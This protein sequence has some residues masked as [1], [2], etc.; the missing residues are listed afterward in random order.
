MK[1]IVHE[2]KASGL[3]QNLTPTE[4]VSVVAIRPHIYRHNFPTGNLK[5]QVLNMSD[6]V[7]G[8][9]ATVDISSIGSDSFFHGYVRFM[10]GV[11]LMKDTEYKIK[12][13]SGGGYSFDESAYC[14]I[15]S[16]YDLRKYDPSYST[17]DG[18]HSPL[19]F[20]VWSQT[21]K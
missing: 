8:E 1:L 4:N 11:G 10:V 21:T 15:C 6:T 17:H 18:L 7:L 5:V 13:V 12:L 16:D 3:T 2:L 19:D 14:G 9:S 20:E